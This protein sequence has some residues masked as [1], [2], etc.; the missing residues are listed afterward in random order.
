MHVLGAGFQSSVWG[1]R[2]HVH[3]VIFHMPGGKHGDI[4]DA[5]GLENVLLEVVIEGH[6]SDTLDHLAG[7]ID[8]N[9]RGRVRKRQDGVH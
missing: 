7:P 4:L 3:Q 5:Q 1:S 2:V 8:S 9:L 6:F